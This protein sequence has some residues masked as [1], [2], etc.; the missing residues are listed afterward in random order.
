MTML[1]QNGKDGLEVDW[2]G[3]WVPV[4]FRENTFVVNLGNMLEHVTYGILKGDFGI[5][6]F[7]QK[8]TSSKMD[9]VENGLR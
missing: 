6:S 8:W 2:H 7:R 4:P 5:Q 3:K 1:M 9:I